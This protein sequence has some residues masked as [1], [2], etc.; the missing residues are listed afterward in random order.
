M[1][2]I[3]V[4]YNTQD[5]INKFYLAQH[6]E[7]RFTD[8]RL[9]FYNTLFDS[10]VFTQPGNSDGGIAFIEILESGCEDVLLLIKQ[11]FNQPPEAVYSLLVNK[12]IIE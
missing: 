6:V 8:N 4:H 10:V 2:S 12:K 9:M 5:N 11:T 7:W 1:N 3:K